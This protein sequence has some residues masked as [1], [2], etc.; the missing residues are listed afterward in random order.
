MLKILIVEDED[1]E[2]K[3]L[4][5]LINI[6]YP[7]Q[8]FLISEASNGRE[9]LD[10]TILFKPDIVL[11]DI[12]MPVMDGLEASDKIKEINKEIE[13]IIL[14]AYDQFE[15]ARR[16]IK[17]GASDYLVK[18]FTESEFLLSLNGII[19]GIRYRKQ[20]ILKQMYIRENYDKAIPFIE[21]EL[22]TQM[23]YGDFSE[24]CKME[25]SKRILEIDSAVG[26]SMIIGNKDKY[27]FKED[28]LNTV[29]NIFSF[30]FKKIIA[31][32]LLGD[33]VVFIF[34]NN[35]ENILFSNRM[36]EI[37]NQI[38]NHF[39]QQEG[40]EVEIGVGNIASNID[41][42][43]SSY[44]KARLELKNN[45]SSFSDKKSIISIPVSNF[46]EMENM[47]SGKIISEDLLGAMNETKGLMDHLLVSLQDMD[48][49][50]IKS[51]LYHS[52]V[53]IKYNVLCF[54]DID[55]YTLTNETIKEELDLLKTISDINNYLGIFNSRLIQNVS[56][57]KNTNNIE[58]INSAKK[59]IDKNYMKDIRLEDVA[60][61]V[62]ISSYYFS[63]IFK[64]Y[65][66]VNYIQYLTKVRM[67]KSKELI[68]EDKLQIKEI[69]SKVGYLDQNYFSRVFKKYTGESPSEFSS[70]YRQYKLGGI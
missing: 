48:L 67:E 39:I 10:Q 64:K 31:A 25:E 11:M 5:Y 62:C 15:F 35:I 4:R 50:L 14:S 51:N 18:P 63:R 16:A 9:A 37:Y 54:T 56:E 40:I 59:F 36:H 42:F 68:I 41:E 33:I 7:E 12:N 55:E 19:E 2:R 20:Q 57:Y 23:L 49:N 6:H 28:T 61:E 29:K 58:I 69:A 60:K 65:E 34:D 3:A 52:L 17:S 32:R 38:K 43:S 13:I 46:S 21:K 70:N 27:V 30:L 47:I 1:F 8:N 45:L 26:C 24:C 66:G 44:N 22:I 53:N